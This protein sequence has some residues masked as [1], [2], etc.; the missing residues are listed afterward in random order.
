M[1]QKNWSDIA[2]EVYIEEELP[3]IEIT[4]SQTEKKTQYKKDAPS[5]VPS[6]ILKKSFIITNPSKNEIYR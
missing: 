4:E 1:I 3:K 2:E 5:Y 6:G